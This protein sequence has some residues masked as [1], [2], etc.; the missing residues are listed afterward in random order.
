VSHFEPIYKVLLVCTGNTCR[1]PMAAGLLRRELG[2]DAERVQVESAGT[3]AW[4]GQAPTEQSR[5]IAAREGVD[6]CAYRSRRL[7]PALVRDADLI[8]VMEPAHLSVTRGMG[9]DSDRVHV[10]S[11]F[12]A[13]G[14]PSLPVVDPYGGSIEAY[15][16]CWRRLERHVQRVVPQIREAL[17]ARS[18]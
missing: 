14:D 6:I 3:S 16:E 11:E 13:P 12:P 8:L 2:P 4:E 15:E 10:L 9:A 7:T 5:E 1:S 17:R 18:A